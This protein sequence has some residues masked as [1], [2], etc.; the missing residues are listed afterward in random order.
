MTD[1]IEV[2]R[3]IGV[4]C[5]VT[6]HLA[7]NFNESRRILNGCTSF[8]FFLASSAHQTSYVLKNYFGL[9]PKQIDAIMA[10]EESRWV[11]L[12]RDVPMTIM[13]D[14]SIFFAS[15]LNKIQ[16]EPRQLKR[17]ESESDYEEYEEY[18]ED[19]D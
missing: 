17:E 6:S 10:I 16:R 18:D 9:S 15:E 7:A 3:S 11:C 13:T 19:S 2:G 14:K 5:I 8:I 12:F 1:I 4:Y